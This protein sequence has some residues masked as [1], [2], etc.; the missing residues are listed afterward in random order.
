MPTE[1]DPVT[2]FCEHHREGSEDCYSCCVK[3]ERER[4]C[5]ILNETTLKHVS[6]RDGSWTAIRDEGLVQIAAPQKSSK[7]QG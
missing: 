1:L 7:E 4:V 3:A 2:C 5:R 6:D